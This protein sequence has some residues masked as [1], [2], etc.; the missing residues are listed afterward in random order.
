MFLINSSIYH[1]KYIIN[2]SSQKNSGCVFEVLRSS[3]FIAS[4]LNGE[5]LG[6]AQTIMVGNTKHPT[7]VG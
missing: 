5:F 1:L 7:K 4:Y 3:S 6:N 2:S